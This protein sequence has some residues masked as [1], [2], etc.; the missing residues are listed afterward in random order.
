VILIIAKGRE[1]DKLL[2]RPAPGVRDFEPRG[3]AETRVT[4]QAKLASLTG[5]G[6]FPQEFGRVL[7]NR[8]AQRKSF[9]LRGNSYSANDRSTTC[10]QELESGTEDASPSPDE[11]ARNGALQRKNFGQRFSWAPLCIFYPTALPIPQ[12]G[13]PFYTLDP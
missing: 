1:L 9:P 2:G 5:F 7:A 10:F 8:P 13:R 11:V 4:R 3:G 6:G 12:T